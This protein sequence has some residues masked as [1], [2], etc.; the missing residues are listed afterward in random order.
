MSDRLPII[1]LAGGNDQLETIPRGFSADDVLRGFK[2]AVTLPSGRCI[3]AELVQR[4]RDSERF[5]EPI[6]VGPRRVYHDLV[7]CE[8]VDTAGNLLSTISAFTE[9]LNERYRERPVA[10]SACDILPTAADFRELL[11]QSYLPYASSGLWWEMIAAT[12]EEMGVSG[13]K[14][15]YRMRMAPGEP[16]LNLY[17]GHLL[18]L[19]ADAVRL[20]WFNRFLMLAYR[21][22]NRSV[23]ERVIRIT[24]RVLWLWLAEDLKRIVSFRWPGRVVA[25]PYGI[26]RTYFQYSRER[27]TVPGLA[28]ELARQIMVPDRVRGLD[29][30]VAMAVTR[31][32][33]FAKDIDTRPELEEILGDAVEGQDGEAPSGKGGVETG[34]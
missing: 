19:R 24:L 11:D 30:P 5:Q 7:D 14:P 6:V 12:P 1:I 23:Y 16:L 9:L 3:A 18:I 28:G 4:V 10:V 13:W 27:L 31:V 25:S 2:G 15:S 8:I 32:R 17:P 34:P 26:F 21:F 29:H 20:D 22:R 33:S